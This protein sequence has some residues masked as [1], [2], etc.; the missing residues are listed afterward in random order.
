M[1]HLSLLLLLLVA[2]PACSRGHGSVSAQHRDPASLIRKT[3]HGDARLLCTASIP[4][5]SPIDRA[6]G[7]ETRVVARD[8]SSVEGWIRLGNAW[9]QKARSSADPGFYLNAG[10]CADVA[11]ELSP[12]NALADNLRG[13]TYLNDHRF[14]EARDLATGILA[15]DSDDPTAWGT[16]ADAELELGN[17]DGAERAVQRM[18]D[19]KPSLASYSRA[20]YLRWLRGDLSGAKLLGGH[21]IRAG[22]EARD[23]EPLAWI[24]V[25]TALVFW[26]EGDYDGALA[27]FDLALSEVPGYAPA[28]VGKAKVALG[29]GRYG[30]AASLLEPALE[31]APLS[32]TA[33]LLGDARRLSGDEPG[34]QKAYER[35]VSEGRA[36]DRRTLSLFL[37]SRRQDLSQA[38][39]LAEAELRDRPSV[40]SKD[41]LSWALYRSGRFVEARELSEEAVRL[42]IPDARLL[43]HAGAIRIATGDVSG[44]KL[45]QQALARNPMFDSLEAEE[46]RRLVQ[47]GV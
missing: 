7:A 37:S 34:A 27:G 36:H 12:D 24:L 23:R 14:R 10:A 29:R 33:W 25:Q 16:L 17:I 42:G 47:H 9:V 15:R 20:A 4:G 26:G 3:S 19:L 32:E 1:K 2:L 18:L 6:I 13:F 31:R 8:P 35:V 44:R 41:A 11:L 22:R 40:Y 21:A 43:F 30:E 28:L 38:V 39:A 5:T 46:A 45:V